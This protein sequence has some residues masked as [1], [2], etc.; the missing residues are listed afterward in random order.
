MVQVTPWTHGLRTRWRGNVPALGGPKSEKGGSSCPR[1]VP[2]AIRQPFC[3]LWPYHISPPGGRATLLRRKKELLRRLWKS[4]GWGEDT[5]ARLPLKVS[6][7]ND[8]EEQSLWGGR[9][10]GSEEQGGQSPTP[11][12]LGLS[13]CHPIVPQKLPQWHPWACPSPAS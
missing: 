3:D 8:S 2:N 7:A 12:S 4:W 5:R 9:E 11:A 10:S 6:K 1:D 13:W